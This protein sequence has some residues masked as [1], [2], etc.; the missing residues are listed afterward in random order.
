MAHRVYYVERREDGRWAVERPHA[1]RASAL[2]DTRA[3][4]L[5][6]AHELSEDGVVNVEGPHGR[7]VRCTCS[8]CS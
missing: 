2:S 6:R 3:A 1:D 5:R 4:A 8:Q 7:F